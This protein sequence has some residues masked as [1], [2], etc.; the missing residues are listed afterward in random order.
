[1]IWEQLTWPEFDK[2]DRKTP[3]I[4]P[5][6]AIEQHGP[7]LPLAT[8]KIIA[9]YFCNELNRRIPQNVLIL[10][11]IAIGCSEHHLGYP[12]SLSV[13][14]ET[15]L[16]QVTDI[17]STV[18]HHGFTNL[19]L[20]NSHGGNQAVGQ[21]FVEK[22]GYRNEGTNVHLITWW[23]VAVE[24]LLEI[25]ETEFGGTGHAGEF[26]TSLMMLIRPDLVRVDKLEAGYPKTTFDWA[27]QDL[28][29]GPRV[30]WFRT[31]NDMTSQGIFGDPTKSSAIKGEK[32]KN[33]V[34]EEC[35]RIL[36]DISSNEY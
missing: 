18:K 36:M 31:F 13:T 7:H 9:E 4:L 23:K 26:E 10:P 15:L 27:R 21:L 19:V 12:G 33:I 25:T 6:A 17:F 35:Q 16:Q 11:A 3:V 24:K 32:I 8:D 28:L 22:F 34:L 29:H 5:V 20:F 1:M 30:S 14:H 2:I